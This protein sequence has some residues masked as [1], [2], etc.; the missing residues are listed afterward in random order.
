MGLVAD[1]LEVFP[2]AL[3]RLVGTGVPAGAAWSVTGVSGDDEWQVASGVGA[4]R[5]VVLADPWAPVGRAV[6]YTLTHGTTVE[7]SVAVE[8]AHKGFDLMTDLWGRGAVAFIRP[9]SDQRTYGPRAEFF[10]PQGSPVGVPVYAPTAARPTGA[11]TARTTGWDTPAMDVLVM[12]NRP[13]VVLHN[14]GRCRMA[15]CTVPSAETVFL[16]G[17]SNDMAGRK[18]QEDRLWSLTTRPAPVP[19]GFVPPV[20]TWGDVRRRFGTWAAVKASGM[21][22]GQLRR[23]DWLTTG[24]YPSVYAKRY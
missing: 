17:V 1:L 15:G 6:S 10:E 11:F 5:D 24:A 8:R 19:H 22:W 13:V 12:A 14:H 3:V 16:T 18:S 20:V 9:H 4:G 2:V 21:T 23:G 7:S